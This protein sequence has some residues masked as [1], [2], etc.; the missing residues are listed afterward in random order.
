MYTCIVC[1][2]EIVLDD[3]AVES[4]SGHS[5]CLRCYTKLT[6]TEQPMPKDLR[7]E[8]EAFLHALAD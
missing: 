1:H 3:V 5:I 8:V 4:Q 7:R 2:F 6:D